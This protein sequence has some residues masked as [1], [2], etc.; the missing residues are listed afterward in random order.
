M[1]GN[2]QGF[3]S[4]A[5]H[6]IVNSTVHGEIAYISHTLLLFELFLVIHVK[7]EKK[8]DCFT[9]FHNKKDRNTKSD[10]LPI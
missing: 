4:S 10:T 9:A 8:K 2:A 7:K 5:W 1:T 6:I 3:T